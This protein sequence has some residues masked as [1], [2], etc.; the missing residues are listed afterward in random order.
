MKKVGNSFKGVL[1]GIIFIIIGVI[2]LWWNEGNNVRN[3]KTTKEM[4]NTVIDVESGKVDSANEGK[5]IATHGKLINEMTLTDDDF[6]VSLVTPKLVR[7]VEVYQWV[8]DSDTDDNGNRTYSYSKQW[9]SDMV[10]S[11]EFHSSSSHENPLYKPYEDKEQY[12]TQVSVGAF[13]LSSDQ[14]RALSTDGVFTSYDLEKVTSMNYTVIGDYLTNS[15][16]LDKPEIGDVRIKITY[17]NSTDVSILAV[18]KGNTFTEYVSS[19]GKT[20]SRIVDGVHTG[21]EMVNII[22]KE[23]NLLKWILRL[24]GTLLCVGGVAAIFKPISTLSSFV[25]ILGGLV[26]TAVGLVALILGL[27]ISLV[28]IAI[29][30]IRFR[31]LVG[32]LLLVA[33]G[34]LVFL[35]IKKKKSSAPIVNEQPQNTT[36]V[37]V[38]QPTPVGMQEP[39]TPEQPQ[40]TNN[41]SNQNM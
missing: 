22:E 41:D 21:K 25:P 17:N 14:I 38:Q 2:L 30:W 35:L 6:G 40:D 15:K 39:V 13:N 3:I 29:A 1:G 23:N 26:N 33:V 5:L 31:P 34:G 10:N 8:E 11:S 16:D 12:S 9:K 28:V 27:A 36:P 7:T 20:E 4:A 32:I 37:G 18:Q 19:V 24:L